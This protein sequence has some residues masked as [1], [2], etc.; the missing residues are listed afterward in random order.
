MDVGQSEVGRE[1]NVDGN[2]FLVKVDGIDVS[3]VVDELVVNADA[4]SD[5][6]GCS[7]DVLVV[8]GI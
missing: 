8:Y 5:D 2:V 7:I 6:G 1:V 3:V 4:E